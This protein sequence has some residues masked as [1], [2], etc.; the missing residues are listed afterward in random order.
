MASVLLC[1]AGYDHTVRFWEA[2]TGNCYR[3]LQFTDSV[4]YRA[5]AL[6]HGSNV[7]F[8]GLL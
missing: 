4:F 8:H 5:E 6:V 3:T 1:T 7:D 2:T